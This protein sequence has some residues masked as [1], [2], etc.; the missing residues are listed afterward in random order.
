MGEIVLK[1]YGI[2]IPRE[3]IQAEQYNTIKSYIDSR[4]KI[5]FYGMPQY[6]P[7]VRKRGFDLLV[8]LGITAIM[9]L[10]ICLLTWSFDYEYI[11]VYIAL[12]FFGSLGTFVL[13]LITF[14]HLRYDIRVFNKRVTK[15]VIKCSTYDEFQNI[16]YKK[17]YL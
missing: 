5:D 7:V 15:L 9:L 6:A 11:R 1:L 2:S 16:Y 17:Y 13:P 3:P 4:I 8:Q 14:A 12:N 10:I